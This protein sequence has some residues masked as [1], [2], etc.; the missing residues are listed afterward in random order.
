MLKSKILVTMVLVISSVVIAFLIFGLPGYFE[1]NP[2]IA[3]KVSIGVALGLIV[4]I[5]R[6]VKQN[7]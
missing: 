4:L 1:P 6:V 7:K 2:V 3:L 5:Y